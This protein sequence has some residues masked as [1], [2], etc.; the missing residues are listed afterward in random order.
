MKGLQNG[1]NQGAKGV[2]GDLTTLTGAIAKGGTVNL[3]A[4]TSIGLGPVRTRGGDGA[5]ASAPMFAQGAIQ[6]NAPQTMSPAQVGQQVA[7]KT[8][9]KLAT[10]TTSPRI[11]RVTDR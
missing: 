2:L 6:V 9:Y 7:S 10:A 1:I 4:A 3:G 8:A 11:P 5:S